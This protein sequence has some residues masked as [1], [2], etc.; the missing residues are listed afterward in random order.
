MAKIDET[1]ISDEDYL[2]SL[3]NS[4]VNNETE[5]R[6]QDNDEQMNIDEN[7][8]VL[9][10]DSD[11]S[12][13]DFGDISFDD[14]LDKSLQ[15]ELDSLDFKEDAASSASSDSI[16]EEVTDV[17]P[18]GI[19]EEVT[20]VKSDDI[21][22]VSDYS[23]EEESSDMQELFEMLN[24][25]FDS[26]QEPSLP[27]ATPIEENVG[28]EEIDED[29]A[30]LLNS[31]AMGEEIHQEITESPEQ[32]SELTEGIFELPEELL[33]TEAEDTAE[34]N[35]QENT[36][37]SSD[38]D[39]L[40]KMLSELSGLA[41]EEEETAKTISEEVEPTEEKKEGLFSRLFG[42]KNKEKKDEKKAKKELNQ[43]DSELVSF[44][45]F[46]L[47][48]IEDR[49]EANE[50]EKAK[51]EKE[52][53]KAKKAQEKKE[54]KEQAKAEKAEKA[55]KKA[56]EKAKRVKPPVEII[57][58]PL[59]MYI[60]IFSVVT[61][62]GLLVFFGSKTLSYNSDINAAT[63]A[64]VKDDYSK[65]YDY[66]AGMD[67][68]SSD[69]NFYDQVVTIMYVEKQYLSYNNYRKIEDYER[70][71]NSLLKGID[72]YDRHKNTANDLNV[73]DDIEISYTKILTALKYDFSLSEKEARAI[74][75]I[76]NE[77]E[78]SDK[79][80]QV[81]QDSL[82]NIENNISKE[83]EEKLEK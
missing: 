83:N 49:T 42:K 61:G 53:E 6:L 37:D 60:L 81:V 23:T 10:D 7:F 39:E 48:D 72:K 52:E 30:D 51:K 22:E 32:N 67:I 5:Q 35:V 27:E 78:Y 45:D 16:E 79:I 66:L 73:L 20:D 76:I 1:N 71:L 8:G 9:S 13:F 50:K 68:K 58:I 11:D 56:E 55:K 18:D 62:I 46:D 24:S 69:K 17:E 34:E 3:L 40:S 75:G 14:L 74:A 38:M 28:Q 31:I 54:K 25:D 59:V 63:K 26:I 29:F 80:R 2:D 43:Q 47:S 44:D 12:W 65:A 57:K 36:N 15:D 41:E 4:V 82:L 64:F 33:G 70:A 21:E 19:E 77:E